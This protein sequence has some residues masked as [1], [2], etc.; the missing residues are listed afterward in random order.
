[1]TH[2][3]KFLLLA[4]LGLIP[5]AL[6]YGLV[7]S[8][9]LPFLF[10]IDASPT[11][12]SHIFRAVMGLYLALAVYWLMG[13]FGTQQMARSALQSLIVFMWGLGLG[14][15]ISMAIDGIPNGILI[16]YLLLEI[17]FGVV[18]IM[19]IKNDDNRVK[20]VE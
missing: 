6:M 11:N 12:V 17:G 2:T 19:L 8:V 4:V 3:Q 9:T 10:D 14:R 16:F 1:M 18:G 5:I 7:P 13:A 15:A 20:Q